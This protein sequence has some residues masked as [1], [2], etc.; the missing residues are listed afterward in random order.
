MKQTKQSA[1]ATKIIDTLQKLR[2]RSHQAKI[3][4]LVYTQAIIEEMTS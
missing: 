4:R 1:V 3:I 2:Y